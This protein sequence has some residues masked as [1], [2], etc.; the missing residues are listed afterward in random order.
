MQRELEQVKTEIDKIS[1]EKNILKSKIEELK[2]LIPQ[3]KSKFKNLI[4]KANIVKSKL[5]NTLEML[6]VRERGKMEELQV[7]IEDE[8]MIVKDIEECVQG[9]NKQ[10]NTKIKLVNKMK[11]LK[12]KCGEQ[13][14]KGAKEIAQ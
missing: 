11:Y 3:E 4:Q 7:Y 8:D 9:L 12:R 13:K 5:M 14:L 1:E 2:I 10:K 6:K